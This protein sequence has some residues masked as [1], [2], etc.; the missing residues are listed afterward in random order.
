MRTGPLRAVVPALGLLFG[1]C[2][3]SPT[4]PGTS[5]PPRRVLDKLVF[6]R[7]YRPGLHDDQGQYMGGT[8]VMSLV[9]FRGRLYAGLGYRNDV[10]GRDPVPGAQV[11][12]KDEA[13]SPWRV[14]ISFGPGHQ[15]I[16][17]L[18]GVRFSTDGRGASL[19]PPVE[20]LVASPS[21]LRS[22]V[23]RLTTVWTRDDASGRWSRS[24][25]A[26]ERSGQG[27]RSFG[28]HRDRTTGIDALFAGAAQGGVYRGV[29]DPGTPGYLRWDGS[30]ELGGAGR[31]MAL[32]EAEGV[33]Y[34]AAGLRVTPEGEVR[35]GVFRRI[36]G[37]PPRWERVYVWP[38]APPGRTDEVH[39]MRGLTGVPNGRG[40]EF[41][42]GARAEPGV[43]ERI[44]PAEGHSV[45]MELDIPRYFASAW[46][47]PR[48][49]TPIPAAYNAIV[50]VRDPGSGE[51]AHLA[52]LWVEHPDSREPF[53]TGSH[54]LV[55]W[56]DGSFSHGDAFDAVESFPGGPRLRATRAIAPSPFFQE[57]GRAVYL[58][59]YDTG[60]EPSHNTAWILRG[61][62]P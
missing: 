51:T 18:A 59:G 55:R 48:L 40:G 6:T 15:R 33:L 23:A 1:S 56:P 28:L 2:A 61:T 44:D 25:I 24:V 34:A 45:L 58:G 46:G 22:G 11:L 26:G 60:R 3:E 29:Y 41:L 47:L 49:A 54:Y 31:I 52:G 10:P 21:D 7:D 30:P 38:A 42:L 16:E 20:M 4:G 35:G 43:V 32:A 62:P 39:V 27:V 36:D 37:Q 50:A 19:E 13:G 5:E 8:E 12:R 53:M 17:G 9:P 57:E 14:D